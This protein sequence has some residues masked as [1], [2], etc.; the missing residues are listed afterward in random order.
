MGLYLPGPHA[1][2]GCRL[3]RMNCSKR[4]AFKRG[5]RSVCFC[6]SVRHAEGKARPAHS[7]VGR[8]S[9]S[10]AACLPVFHVM[11]IIPTTPEP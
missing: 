3:S 2:V 5:I 8:S 1:G 6:S 9:S 4:G 11:L 7:R 10:G